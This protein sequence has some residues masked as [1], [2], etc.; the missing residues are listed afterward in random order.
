MALPKGYIHS[1]SFKKGSIPWN[2]GLN[3]HLNSEFEFKKGHIPWNKGKKTGIYPWNK[4]LSIYLGGKRFEKGHKSWNWKG[5]SVGYRN[6][7]KWAERYLGKAKECVVCGSLGSKKRNCDWAN[8]SGLYKR[9]IKDFI[10]LC[11]FCHKRWD[12]G[13]LPINLFEWNERRI[14]S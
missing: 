7:H 8:L 14:L 1:G 6:L 4:G 13:R 2:K 9:D 12:M 3:I 10:S 11:R 5:D